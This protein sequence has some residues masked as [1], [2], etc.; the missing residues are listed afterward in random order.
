[1]MELI[2]HSV[3]AFRIWLQKK[4]EAAKN[5]WDQF[6]NDE[7]GVSSIVATI[8]LILIVVLLAVIFW[9]SIKSFLAGLFKRITD[10]G[11]DLG[12]DVNSKTDF[13]SI[14]N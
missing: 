9:N 2:D 14:G 12:N 8:I 7:A 6:K 5:Q 4:E 11:N 10:T 1:M 13:N 3:I